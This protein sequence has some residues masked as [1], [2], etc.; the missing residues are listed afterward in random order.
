[1]VEDDLAPGYNPVQFRSYEL[2]EDDLA[3]G[4]NP[5][6]FRSFEREF[7]YSCNLFFL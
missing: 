5:V 6:P 3:P 4:C 2:M 7:D 1:M